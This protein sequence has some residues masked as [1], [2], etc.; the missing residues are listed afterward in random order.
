MQALGNARVEFL[1]IGGVAANLHGSARA[2]F[3]LDLVYSR[4]QENIRRLVAALAPCQPYL[5]GAPPGLPFSFDEA[6]VKNGLNFTLTTALGDI[7]LLGEVVGGGTYE[8]LLA[9]T[10]E[11]EAFGMR[12]RCVTLERLIQLKRAAGRPK[13]LE[14]LAELTALLESRRKQTPPSS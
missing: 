7:D 4:K 5:R 12:C 6:T 10:S 3:D 13:D 11:M 2:T 8:Q 1:V 14:S 9:F